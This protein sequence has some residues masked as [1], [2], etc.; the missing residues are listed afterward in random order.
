MKKVDVLCVGVTSYDFYFMVDHHPGP[1]EKTVAD[2]FLS[3]G[4]GPAANAAV[5][6]AK[7]GLSS[8]FAGYLGNDAWGDQ[9]LKE[10][11]EAGVQT[12]L[13]VRGTNPTPVSAIFV[14][15]DGGRSLVNYQV[16][17]AALESD[18]VD[19]SNIQPRIILFDGHEP[20][21]SLKL[22]EYAKQEKIITMLDAG[23]LHKGTLALFDK[24][25]YLVCSEKFAEQI[26]N[27]TSMQE[28]LVYLTH[29]NKNIVITLGEQGLIWKRGQDQGGLPALNINAID[30]TG[31]GDVFHGAFAGSLAM[32]KKWPEILKYS[33]AAAA[34]CCTRAGGRTSIPGIKEVEDFLK[35]HNL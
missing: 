9:H 10:L 22:I 13:V 7:M 32:G 14:K 6:I 4:G 28:A 12:E 1:D 16:D 15:P 35:Y 26:S 11:K 21:L 29:Y 34:L 2:A 8:S 3:C 27:K 20:H 30:T 18:A 23:S 5:T 24:V 25:D 33:S 19:F 17:N 31:A